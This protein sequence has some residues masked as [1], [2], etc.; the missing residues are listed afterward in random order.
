MIDIHSHILPGIDDGAKDVETSIQMLKIAQADGIETIMATPHFYKG[1]WEPSF[2]TVLKKTEELKEK[3]QKE[4]LT[5]NI[6]SGQEVLLEDYTIECINKG[7]V[8]GINGSRYILV[9]FPMYELPGNYLDLIYE[10]R[11]MNLVPIIAHPERYEYVI[12]KPYLVNDI[13]KEGC[14]LQLNAGSIT[15]LFGKEAE[16]TAKL[17]LENG[18][19]HFIASDAHS[20]RG[21]KPVL[22][23]AIEV[24]DD[25]D[26]KLLLNIYRNLS[27]LCQNEIIKA[28]IK[29]IE[30]KKSLFN[31]FKKKL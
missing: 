6:L 19:C 5:I 26:E 15:G 11:I 17:L 1:A 21:R 18:A 29:V 9:E 8:K 28:P 25:I 31:L 10:L 20:A 7:L 3:A 4:G 27:K 14:L 2:D 13:L 16:K 12:S 24:I 22:K 23:Q 30:Q